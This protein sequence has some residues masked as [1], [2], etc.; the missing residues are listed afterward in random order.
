MN[1]LISFFILFLLLNILP[2]RIDFQEFAI[3]QAKPSVLENKLSAYGLS[4]L[5]SCEETNLSG[6]I[7]K[8][9]YI[10]SD[11]PSQEYKESGVRLPLGKKLIMQ[12]DGNFDF[13]SGA[14]LFQNLYRLDSMQQRNLV[15]TRLLIL[16]GGVWQPARYLWNAR[17]T[18]AFLVKAAYSALPNDH[19]SAISVNDDPSISSENDCKR[20]HNSDGRI[21]PVATTGMNLN[22]PVLTKGK[23]VEQLDEL[24]RKGAIE[25][26]GDVMFLTKPCDTD[27]SFSVSERARSYLDSR[28]AH[29]HHPGNQQTAEL[30]FNFQSPLSKTG[31]LARKKALSE[32]LVSPDER[33][34]N[35]MDMSKPEAEGV[36]L[37]QAFL[38]SLPVDTADL[39]SEKRSYR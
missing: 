25:F 18:E 5:D 34:G 9:E 17:K 21:M 15:E 24:E 3:H 37:V 32:L 35:A 28:C 23:W 14:I 38:K 20:C 11:L 16:K 39:F 10:N 33:H 2:G 27:S 31:I 8:L 26:S 30:D 19:P 4:L 1:S 13:P 22:R 12:G 6:L 36:K 29:C 7:F